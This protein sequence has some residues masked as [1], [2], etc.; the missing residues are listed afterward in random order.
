[1][2]FEDKSTHTIACFNTTDQVLRYI[3]PQTDEIMTIT[4]G[5]LYLGH[6]VIDSG[7]IG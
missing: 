6:I 3:E 7:I 2:V 5:E 1:M 4:I